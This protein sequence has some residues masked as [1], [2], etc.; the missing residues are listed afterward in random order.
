MGYE[1]TILICSLST[2][3]VTAFIVLISS[4]VRVAFRDVMPA[5]LS[6]LMAF[7]K[8]LMAD[9]CFAELSLASKT[10]APTIAGKFNISKLYHRS[11]IYGK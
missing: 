7:S 2:P 8:F 4:L 11:S 5:F 1:R 6:L 10:P 3:S 9:R